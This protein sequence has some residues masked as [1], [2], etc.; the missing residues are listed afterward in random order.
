[1]YEKEVLT[2]SNAFNLSHCTVSTHLLNMCM[3]S[4]SN[5]SVLLYRLLKLYIKDKL[6]KRLI[7]MRYIINQ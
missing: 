6:Q 1:M 2:F 5:K 4:L 7:Q 3:W